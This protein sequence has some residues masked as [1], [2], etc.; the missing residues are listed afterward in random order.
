MRV[1]LSIS[2]GTPHWLPKT[3]NAI[4]LLSRSFSLIPGLTVSKK[5]SIFNG[6]GLLFRLAS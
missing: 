6:K 2:A 1:V 4:P 3:L 5:S